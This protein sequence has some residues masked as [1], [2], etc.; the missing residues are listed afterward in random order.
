MMPE[1][2]ANA[3]TPPMTNFFPRPIRTNFSSSAMLEMSLTKGLA[4]QVGAR[5]GGWPTHMTGQPIMLDMIG[6]NEDNEP[7]SE[8]WQH[9][10]P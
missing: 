10:Q 7:D 1:E 3:P 4:P 5:V 8:W 6:A 9:V 2:T